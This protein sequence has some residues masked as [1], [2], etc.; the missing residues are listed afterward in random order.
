MEK[1]VNDNLRIGINTSKNSTIALVFLAALKGIV[2]LYSGSTV[3]IADAVHTSLDIFTSLA[4]W[5]GLRLSLK[6]SGEK[7]PY[8]YYKAENLIALF[9]SVL[10][11]VSGVE[12]L[13]Q[14]LASINNPIEIEIQGIALGT[15][16]FSVF[17]IY[18]ISVYKGKIGKQIDSQA[19][20]A[21]A[22][23]S[24]T[25]VFSSLV[26]VIAIAGSML[27]MPW[28]DSIG[29]LVISLMIFRLGIGIARDS[30]L[31]LMDAWLDKESIV[32]I[33]QAIGDIKGINKVEDIRLRKSGLVVFGEVIVE[34]QGDVDL[35]KVEMLS[36]EIKSAVKK[37]VDNLEHVVVNAK[38]G[39]MAVVKVAVPVV[40]QDG[41]RSKLSLHLGKAPYFII[42]EMENDKFKNWDVI[43]NPAA[44]LE[45]K[46]GVKTA[47][48][49]ISRD[50]N[51]L[52]IHDIGDGPFHV[53]RDNFVKILQ[54][55]GS[56][57]NVDDVIGK[58]HEF[59]VITSPTEDRT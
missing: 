34:T 40:A 10:I 49:L 5:V 37:E 17:V 48:F 20:I 25:D 16:V 36:D 53:L 9:V 41:L 59:D 52:I 15:A 14:A 13:R 42:I 21:N 44:T 47:E 6:D 22:M 39:K 23:H 26:V 2:G 32:R 58:V 56:A 28:L 4:V 33:R 31:I 18:A 11:L 7:F 12:L 30:I 54:M 27:G 46:K 3:L 50:V 8:G 43:K 55:P 51:V 1:R 38:P 35:K 19:L 24:Y 45:K 29:V 57:K